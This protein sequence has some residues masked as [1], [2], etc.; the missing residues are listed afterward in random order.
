M[1]F[2][3]LLTQEQVV[4]IHDAALEILE[5]VGLRVRYE[6]ATALTLGAYTRMI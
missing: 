4:R 6:P 5:E 2:A 3:E 1:S